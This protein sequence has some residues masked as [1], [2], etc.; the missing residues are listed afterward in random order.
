[1]YER[2]DY[3]HEA[4]GLPVLI[5]EFSWNT[6]IIK[7]VTLHGE[8]GAGLPVKERMFKR[9]KM[10]LERAA[11]HPASVG[12]TWYRWVQPASTDKKFTDGLV[13]YMDK[14]D[15]HPPKLAMINP[16]L[17][18]IRKYHK[19]EPLEKGIHYGNLIFDGVTTNRIPVME[20]KTAHGQWNDTLYGWQ[21]TGKLEKSS[22]DS[23]VSELTMI[24]KYHTWHHRD[25]TIPGGEGRYHILLE[26]K[27]NGWWKGEFEGIFKE[28]PVS[29][30]VLAYFY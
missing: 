3:I 16:T 7:K 1:M 18:S 24:V 9:G 29:G 20:F 19:D 6:D 26:K 12:Y 27:T 4:T 22:M 5:G 28:M 13:D 23:T 25:K 11:T 21:A 30:K 2:I 17:D 8:S 15:I 10:I 14:T